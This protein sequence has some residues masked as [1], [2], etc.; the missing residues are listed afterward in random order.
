MNKAAFGNTVSCYHLEAAITF[1]HCTAENFS[2]T[3]WNRILDY[4]ELLCS[5]SFSPITELNKAVA[6]MQ[7]HGAAKALLT[8]QNIADRK[9]LETFYLYYSLLGEIYSRLNNSIEAKKYFEK[10][11]NITQSDAEKKIIKE[12]IIALLN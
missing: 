7:V 6:V 3:N 8:L 4:Y 5:I 11:I 12:K 2:K 10:S 1:E 9:K